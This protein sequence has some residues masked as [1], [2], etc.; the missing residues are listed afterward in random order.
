L[1]SHDDGADLAERLASWRARHIEAR[2]MPRLL[3]SRAGA[4]FPIGDARRTSDHLVRLWAA[5]EVERLLAVGKPEA[6]AEA[7]KLAAHHQI[8]TAVT[9]AV[10]LETQAQ[11][12]AAGL[13]PVDPASVPT[14][15]EPATII[16]SAIV[17]LALAL[18]QFL[19]RR[20][21]A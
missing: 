5:Q 7:V 14:I 11:Y 3:T 2:P 17:L 15:P 1:V 18:M 12:D 10:V 4:F 13:T 19:S 6:R 20:R 8:V 9:G 21:W 16:L